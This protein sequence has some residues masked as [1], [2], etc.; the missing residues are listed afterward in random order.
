M[1]AIKEGKVEEV[2]NGSAKVKKRLISVPWEMKG[3][4]VFL[5]KEAV[6]NERSGTF[7]EFSWD[8]VLSLILGIILGFLA[9]PLM[10]SRDAL[11]HI[12]YSCCLLVL[13]LPWGLAGS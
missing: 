1:S 10:L 6:A 3:H 11:L 2:Q 13:V 4:F 8:H 5:W 12:L 7:I 9:A